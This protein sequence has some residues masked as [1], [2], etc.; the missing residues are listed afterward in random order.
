MPSPFDA[1]IDDLAA[2][3]DRRQ[4]EAN[5]RAARHAQRDTASRAARHAAEAQRNRRLVR[6]TV[7]R[8]LAKAAPVDQPAPNFEAIAAR[9]E[10]IAQDLEQTRVAAQK[11][12]IRAHIATLMAAAKA[13]RLDPHS[14]CVLDVLRGRALAMGLEP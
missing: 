11:D 14:V 9:Q 6:A 7:A 12:A 8:R 3:R 5:A 2:L 13:G 10:R 1:L 4:I